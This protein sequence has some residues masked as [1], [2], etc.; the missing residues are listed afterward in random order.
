MNSLKHAMRASG[1]TVREGVRV[2]QRD[3][4]ARFGCH[5]STVSLALRGHPSIP[6]PVRRQIRDLAEQMGYRADP[7]LALLARNRF[8]VRADAPSSALAYLVHSGSACYGTH[9]LS[10]WPS[11]RRRAEERGFRLELFDLADHRSGDTVTRELHRR[12]IRGVVIPRMP[13]LAEPYFAGE[14]WRWFAVACCSLGWVRPPFHIIAPD[15]FDAMRRLWIEAANRNYQRIGGAVF[16]HR[17][18]SEDDYARHGAALAEQQELIPAHRRLPILLCGPEDR[19]A[20]LAW[21]KRH[22][23][24]AIVSFLSRAY[25][26]LIEAGYRVP[27][28]VAFACFGVWPHEPF[29]GFAVPHEELG[30]ATVDFLIEQLHA[31]QHGFPEVRQTVRHERRWV[32]GRTLPPVDRTRGRASS[33]ELAE[34]Q[35]GRSLCA[36]PG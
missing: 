27:E 4:A 25:E 10:F 14:G 11:V 9:Q 13:P 19:T 26:W 17:P 15:M 22:R 21:V 16:R 20:F 28:D 3:V 34:R 8:V 24:D 23:P 35:Q 5:R 33:F 30:R 31:N 29:T 2:T 32:E 18:A 6:E 7:A 36:V 1:G 12:G